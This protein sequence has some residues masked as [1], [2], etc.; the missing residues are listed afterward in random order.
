M[1]KPK[2]ILYVGNH[3][4]KPGINPT[5]N[6]YLVPRLLEYYNVIC[7]STKEPKLLRLIDMIRFLIKNRNKADVV[8]IDVYSRQGYWYAILIA[9]M[10]HFYGIPYINLLHGGNLPVR[11]KRS[12]RISKKLFGQ[13][14]HNV[15]PS[16]YMQN[17]F[18][19]AGFRAE[20]L[21][22]FI[23]IEEYPFHLRTV[24]SAQLFWLRSF[25]KIYNPLLA[26]KV[27]KTLVN[28]GLDAKLCMVGPEKDGTFKE[29][30]AL[31]KK[32][33]VVD[34]LKI[35]GQ[36]SRKE[37]IKISDEY[38]IFINTTDFDNHPV[39][40]LEA[41]AFGMPIVSTNVGGLP[42]LID[43]EINGLLVPHNDEVVFADAIIDLVTNPQKAFDLSSNARKKVETFTWNALKDKWIDIIETC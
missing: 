14:A 20:Y 33:K 38:D 32:L 42:C 34:R 7:T 12:T 6:F 5:F 16:I 13:A 36:L 4:T 11:L 30:L 27:L 2:T 23:E 15:S 40:V 21:P 31:A 26:I 8:M 28:K 43:N 1:I 39:S 29:T 35:A 17:I 3:L 18:L 41:M 22:N 24:V 37:W 25:H 9:K 19:E 10:A